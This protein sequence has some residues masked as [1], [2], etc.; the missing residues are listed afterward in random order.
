MFNGH[1][2]YFLF[3]TKSLS[4]AGNL[5]HRNWV[6]HCSRKSSATQSLSVCALFLCVKTM[7]WLPVFGIFKVYADVDAR[8]YTWGLNGYYQSLHWM[9]TLGEQSTAAHGTQ[10]RIH[11]VSGFSFRG[12]T[13]W[14]VPAL[15]DRLLL[16]GCKILRINLF[17]AFTCISSFN[18]EKQTQWVIFVEWV[19][20]SISMER[21]CL[22][23][24]VLKINATFVCKFDPICY[25]CCAW[26]H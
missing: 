5:S 23:D 24:H 3:F 4:L 7:V 11:T 1:I 12:S 8:N 25:E 2:F 26:A 9:L 18:T 15:Y 10:S 6:R 20:W 22:N 21:T 17:N 19:D 14:A 13:N 16:T